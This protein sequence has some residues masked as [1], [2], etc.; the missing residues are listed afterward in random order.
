[1]G[2]HGSSDRYLGL[3]CAL[4]LAVLSLWPAIIGGRVRIWMLLI[5]GVLL[6]LSVLRPELLRPLNTLWIA[7]GLFVPVPLC[8]SFFSSSYFPPPPKI[9]AAVRPSRFDQA[10]PPPAPLL[11]FF[12]AFCSWCWCCLPFFFSPGALVACRSEFVTADAAG[13]VRV[14][15]LDR[16]SIGGVSVD[17]ASEFAS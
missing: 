12:P 5:A 3:V 8:F 14:F 2:I 4:V 9:F 13:G 7:F 1:M 15:P 6:A 11:L 10:A 17:V 16:P